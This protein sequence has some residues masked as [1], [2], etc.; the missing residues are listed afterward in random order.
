MAPVCSLYELVVYLEE[1]DHKPFSDICAKDPNLAQAAETIVS[2]FCISH[3]TGWQP[4]V[5]QA[6][7]LVTGSQALCKQLGASADDAGLFLDGIITTMTKL[8]QVLW[9]QMELNYNQR[10]F[11]LKFSPIDPKRLME[12]LGC[13]VYTDHGVIKPDNYL[14]E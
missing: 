3:P 4:S 10:S 7:A 5:E 11:I 2:R 6:L 1:L 14:G 12:R 9:P 8:P 13:C